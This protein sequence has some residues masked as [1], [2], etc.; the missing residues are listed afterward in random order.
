MAHGGLS[1]KIYFLYEWGNSTNGSFCLGCDQFKHYSFSV[2][3]E[4]ISWRLK[5]HFFL[6]LG[7][8]RESI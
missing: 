4:S 2:S 3:H 7:E 5:D 8:L 6:G 1:A